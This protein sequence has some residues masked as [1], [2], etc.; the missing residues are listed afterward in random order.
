[1]SE[2]GQTHSFIGS[3]PP[4]GNMLV[5]DGHGA[6]KF[7]VAVPESEMLKATEAYLALI[8]KAFLVTLTPVDVS[9]QEDDTYGDIER[10]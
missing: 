1:M 4:T 6:A 9:I 5:A 8:G 10:L 2:A 7:T 3:P